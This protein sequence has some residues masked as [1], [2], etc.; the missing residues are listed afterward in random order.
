[1]R[2]FE[3]YFLY[4]KLYLKCKQWSKR[5]DL[6]ERVSVIIPVYNSEKF[7]KQSIES[8]INQ[9][10]DNVE[11][12]TVDDGS[13][14][15]SGEILK[16]YSEKIK[17]ISQENKGLAS[18]LNTGLKAIT[19]KWFKWFSPD[20]I[21]YP[22]ALETLVSELKNL[23]DNTIIYSN[24]DLID[25]NEKKL[26]SFSESNYNKLNNF[27]FNVRLL[28]GQQVNVNTALVPASL[29]EQECN[30]EDLEE[31][32]AI[33]YDF[34]L[35]AGILFNTKFYLIQK[36]LVGY[37]ISSEQL[38]HKNVPKTLS[39]RDNVR[40]KVLSKLEPKQRELYEN[41]LKEYAT[42]KPISKKTLKFGL[43]IATSTLPDW[44]TDRLLVFYLNKIRSSR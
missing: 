34:F 17:V 26:R 33:D 40:N 21:L 4:S 32:V 6:S 25:E 12:I 20:D 22:T 29:L 23:S 24:W 35:K 9:T 42:T 2:K 28:D 43:K 8:V 39:F 41:A 37:R 5:S 30:I 36:S 38:S 19:G 44:V 27:D 1:L 31:P 13:T 10:Y 7:L 16:Q 15:S 18:A 3:N 14:D 11:I